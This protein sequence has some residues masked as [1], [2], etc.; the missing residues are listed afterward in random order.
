MPAAGHL[1][2][3]SLTLRPS[4]SGVANHRLQLVARGLGIPVPRRIQRLVGIAV[5]AQIVGHDAK[6]FGEVAVDLAHPRQIALREPGDEQDFSPRRVTPFLRG[7][8]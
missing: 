4:A 5:A 6:L 7:Y 8:G 1:T 3:P 2:P